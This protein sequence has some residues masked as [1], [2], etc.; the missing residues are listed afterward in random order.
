[1]G[2]I[3]DEDDELFVI[4]CD[5]CH[6]VDPEWFM[7]KDSIWQSFARQDELL[8]LPCYAKR[9]GVADVG[10]DDFDWNLRITRDNFRRYGTPYS[11]P[12]SEPLLRKGKPRGQIRAINSQGCEVSVPW[13]V[14]SFLSQRWKRRNWTFKTPARGLQDIEAMRDQA[15]CSVLTQLGIPFKIEPRG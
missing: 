1:M 7:V 15:F 6:R 3:L 2:Y 9:R 10:R 4:F 8:C 13:S 14:L 5:D 11:T 12:F